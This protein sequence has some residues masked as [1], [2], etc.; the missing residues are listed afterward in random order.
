MKQILINSL[1]EDQRL[2][3]PLNEIKIETR[4]IRA[5]Q[6]FDSKVHNLGQL[7]ELFFKT[8]DS[9]L[10][11]IPNFGRRSL[12][13]LHKLMHHAF[14]NEYLKRIKYVKDVAEIK[15]IFEKDAY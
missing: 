9:E 4:I 11:R 3:I 1:P 14:M 15:Y 12:N 13:S 10:L 5:I 8:N 2:Q 7:K 6:E